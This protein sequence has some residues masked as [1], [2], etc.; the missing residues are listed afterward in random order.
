[1]IL[2]KVYDFGRRTRYCAMWNCAKE[3]VRNRHEIAPPPPQRVMRTRLTQNHANYSVISPKL[4][5]A[6][7]I[8]FYRSWN[9]IMRAQLD[10]DVSLNTDG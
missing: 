4:Q 8:S 7:L 10:A 1:M 9:A 2:I 6:W 3:E 5:L